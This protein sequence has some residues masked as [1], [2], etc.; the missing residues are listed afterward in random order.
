MKILYIL[1]SQYEWKNGCWLYRCRIPGV[2]LSERGHEVQFMT[3][4]RDIV[5]EWL[6]FPDVVVYGRSYAMDPL[7]SIETYKKLGKKIVYDLDDDVWSVNPD[8]PAQK[9]AKDK[10]E[11]CAALLTEADVVTTTTELFK[12]RL[13]KF[14]KNI[15]VCPNALDFEKFPKRTKKNERLRIGYTGAASHWG[16]ASLI[17]DVIFELQKKYDFDFV[18]QGMTGMAII[19]EVYSS[20]QILKQGAEPERKHYHESIL[21]MYK[22]LKKLRYFHIPFYPPELYPSVL[23]D[24]N[25][26]IGVAPLQDNKFN[27]VKSCIKFYE[28]AVTGT[29]TLASKVLPYSE[30]VG[31]CAKNNFKD[32]KKKLE[33]LIKDEGFREKLLKKQWAFVQKNRDIKKIVEIWEKV[34]KSAKH[35]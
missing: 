8:N 34:F 12:K 35:Y 31:Y 28:Y 4:G 27:Q 10:R 14:N 1:N 20:R 2:E 29:P 7:P 18:L 11:Q 26:D 5:Q 16:D 32:W 13:Q 17:L 9:A 30:E 3:L 19:A 21:E 25:L 23:S 6:D 24:C 22:K 33:K 15:V